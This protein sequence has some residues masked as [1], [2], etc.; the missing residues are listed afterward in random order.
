M[1]KFLLL[2]SSFC[3]VLAATASAFLPGAVLHQQHLRPAFTIAAAVPAPK[4]TLLSLNVMADDDNDNDAKVVFITGGSQGLGQAFAY[5]IAKQGQKLVINYIAGLEDQ[6]EATVQEC[7]KL[8]GDAIALVG[9]GAWCL[10]T[11]VFLA[12]I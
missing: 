9:D 5:D 7:K 11:I 10:V 12:M 1:M 8:G 3:L 6:A 4:S 2:P